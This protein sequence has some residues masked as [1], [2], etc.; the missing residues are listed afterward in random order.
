MSHWR[1]ARPASGEQPLAGPHGSK[2]A[3][4]DGLLFPADASLPRSYLAQAMLDV[5]T[6]M[7]LGDL[8][9]CIAV[10]MSRRAVSRSRVD[11]LFLS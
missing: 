10:R 5:L 3:L 7:R 2:Y 8:R 11:T 9:N 1:T 4:P 6:L